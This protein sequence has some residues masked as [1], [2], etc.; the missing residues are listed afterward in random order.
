[1]SH[2]L[3]RRRYPVTVK[4][5]HRFSRNHILHFPENRPLTTTA[6]GHRLSIR[7]AHEG[8]VKAEALGS[9]TEGFW[10]FSP[11]FCLYSQGSTR[12]CLICKHVVG[13]IARE[14]STL[15]KETLFL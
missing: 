12:S 4:V 5:A 6:E 13:N 10:E 2:V 15:L 3:L 11:C 7:T 9:V 14:V 1:M 8:G